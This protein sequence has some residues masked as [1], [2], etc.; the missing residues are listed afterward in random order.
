M[1]PV[2]TYANA[3][4]EIIDIPGVPPQ[5]GKGITRGLVGATFK[6]CKLCCPAG[7]GT[8][9]LTTNEP[10]STKYQDCVPVP[11]DVTG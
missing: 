9:G 10:E 6:P 5:G 3:L 4:A 2:G 11:R 7:V 1:C 8:C